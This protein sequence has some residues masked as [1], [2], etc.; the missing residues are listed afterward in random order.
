MA[1]KTVWI[2]HTVFYCA[3]FFVLTLDGA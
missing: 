1:K 2:D 3:A